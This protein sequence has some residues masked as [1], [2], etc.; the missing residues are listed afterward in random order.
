MAS[1]ITSALTSTLSATLT[2]TA[3]ATTT[4]K[5]P[6][7][8]ENPET[9]AAQKSSGMSLIAFFS[10]MATA[11]VIFGIQMGLFLALRTKL[12]RILYVLL[13]YPSPLP[14]STACRC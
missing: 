9:G 4:T 1:T 13:P 5:K 7:T 10:A 11:M 2:T 12:A 8:H 3:A 14:D 6:S